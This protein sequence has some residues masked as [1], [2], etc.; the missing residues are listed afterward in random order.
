MRS[1][2]R[3]STSSAD[4]R[5]GRSAD[6]RQDYLGDEPGSKSAQIPESDDLPNSVTMGEM[7]RH[8]PDAGS[9]VP[10]TSQ[11]E[12]TP[13]GGTRVACDSV[14]CAIAACD[15]AAGVWESPRGSTPRCSGFC[16]SNW[17]PGIGGT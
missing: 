8:V 1:T 14:A 15:N 11:I 3:F 12:E 17:G 4:F 10:V 7:T 2:G 5:P 9:Y 6:S 13:T 16:A